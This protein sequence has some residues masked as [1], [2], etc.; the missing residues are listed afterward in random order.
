[1]SIDAED[2]SGEELVDDNKQI[3]ALLKA[4]VYLLEII[5]SVD[6]GSTV[7]MFED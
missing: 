3:I 2:K 4:Q 7:E 5:A 1:M 6:S